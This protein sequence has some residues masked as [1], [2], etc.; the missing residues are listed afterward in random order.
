MA[1]LIEIRSRLSDNNLQDIIQALREW[2]SSDEVIQQYER[3]YRKARAWKRI[4]AQ[5]YYG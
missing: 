3:I 1:S 4:Q 2:G 5:P